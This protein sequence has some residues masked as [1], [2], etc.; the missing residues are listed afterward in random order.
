MG[1]VYLTR[2]NAKLPEAGSTALTEEIYQSGRDEFTAYLSGVFPL[3]EQL[4]AIGRLE[5][6]DLSANQY[7]PTAGQYRPATNYFGLGGGAGYSFSPMLMGSAVVTYYSGE[8]NDSND[9]TGLGVAM[10]LTFRYR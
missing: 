7:D 1:L 4:Q 3:N 2:S 6:R 5:Y 9:L 8:T 10:A